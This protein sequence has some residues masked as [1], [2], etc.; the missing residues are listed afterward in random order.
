MAGAPLELLYR[1]TARDQAFPHWGPFQA[2]VALTPV[3]AFRVETEIETWDAVAP[4]E[5]TVLFVTRM[6]IRARSQAG[7]NI[8]SVGIE[9][10]NRNTGV[11]VSTPL[12]ASE[13]LA[14]GVSADAFDNFDFA[15]LIG[16]FFIRGFAIFSLGSLLHVGELEVLGY[17]LPQGEIGFN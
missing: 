2:S 15:V 9:L 11:T 10:V 16:R 12:I 13:V 1:L 6:V 5:G 8:S 7:T 4:P 14:N 17:V 3:V